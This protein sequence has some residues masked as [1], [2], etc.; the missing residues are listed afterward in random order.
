MNIKRPLDNHLISNMIIHRISRIEADLKANH[1]NIFLL[2]R[3]LENIDT[4]VITLTENLMSNMKKEPCEPINNTLKAIVTHQRQCNQTHKMTEAIL[5]L[6]IMTFKMLRDAIE[7]GKLNEN[8]ICNKMQ[9]QT[10]LVEE[11]V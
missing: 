5:A 2:Q 1:L 9:E 4:K 6:I 7:I 10:N 8:E 11:L 3:A